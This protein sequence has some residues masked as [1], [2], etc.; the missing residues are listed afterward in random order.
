MDD[1]YI[2]FDPWLGD[3]WSVTD[4]FGNEWVTLPLDLPEDPISGQ[5][6]EGHPFWSEPQSNETEI[7][8]VNM[9]EMAAELDSDA[10]AGIIDSESMEDFPIDAGGDTE[11]LRQIAF[12]DRTNLAED[13]LFLKLGEHCYAISSDEKDCATVA[14]SEG[15][16]IFTD[17]DM[18]GVVDRID[19]VTFA[20]VH[21]S[22]RVPGA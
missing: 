19:S 17:E 4:P 2:P 9:G 14:Y 8:F 1:T 10:G 20:G 21:N 15:L 5:K 22:W 6:V 7:T 12:S 18:D 16:I 11:K 13:E 3:V